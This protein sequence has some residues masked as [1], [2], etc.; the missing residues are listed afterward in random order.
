[1]TLRFEP[2]ATESIAR[3]LWQ[4]AREQAKLTPPT[5][6]WDAVRGEWLVLVGRYAVPRSQEHVP[7]AW[8]YWAFG[9]AAPS[10]LGGT[11]R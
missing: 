1:M 8:G 11:A 2:A 10:V 7:S 6:A 9:P 5:E 3:I 4:N